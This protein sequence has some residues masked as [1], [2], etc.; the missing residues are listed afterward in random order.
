MNDRP[1]ALMETLLQLHRQREP[2]ATIR[3]L[4]QGLVPEFGQAVGCCY[5]L[6]QAGGEFRLEVLDDAQG[7]ISPKLRRAD[8]RVPVTV[9]RNT[10]G[11]VIE[12]LAES[13]MPVHLTDRT[14]PILV[15]LWGESVAENVCKLLGVKFS[16]IAPVAIAEE[17]LGVA[18]LFAID[19]WPIEVAAEATAHAAVAVANLCE[20][21]ET[22]QVAERDPVTGLFGR[23]AVESA[24]GREINRADR[25]RRNFS[26]AVLELPAAEASNER[27]KAAGAAVTRVMR[28]PDTAGHLERN[29][30][31]VL[32]PETPAGGATIFNQR[33]RGGLGSEFDAL[34]TASATFPQDGRTWDEL[35]GTS[36][37]RLD[38]PEA[39]VVQSA[40]GA[41]VPNASVRGSLRAAFP[42]FRTGAERVPGAR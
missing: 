22:V 5:L 24:A 20:R 28:V 31:V 35:V 29:R 16:A 10:S 18:M 11:A 4:L 6:D 26:V 37:A 2:Q 38:Q 40:T 36:I 19:G 14:P 21:R 1:A 7:D 9:P 27:I 32:L 30:I 39:P 15:E 25:Y 41:A 42:S 8:L 12:A 33:V 3:L 23:G 17:A 34:R 13:G